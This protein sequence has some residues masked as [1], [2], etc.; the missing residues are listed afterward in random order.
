MDSRHHRS[1][2]HTLCDKSNRINPQLSLLLTAAAVFIYYRTTSN[3]NASK[4]SLLEILIYLTTAFF[5]FNV[6]MYLPPLN[7]HPFIHKFYFASQETASFIRKIWLLVSLI[8][9]GLL[10]YLNSWR[11]LFNN[12]NENAINRATRNQTR[13]IRVRLNFLVGWF[14]IQSSRKIEVTFDYLPHSGY[15]HS[16]CIKNLQQSVGWKSE[17][18]LSFMRCL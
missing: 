1:K 3:T 17:P 9:W 16:G 14:R 5:T 2:S 8:V 18:A 12:M 15:L 4:R 13:G 10:V 11:P 6:C 7:I